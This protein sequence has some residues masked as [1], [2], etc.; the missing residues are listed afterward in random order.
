M[1]RKNSGFTLVELVVIVGMLTVLLGLLVPSLNSILGFR[2]RRAAGAI[3]SALS[4]TKVE[5]MNRLVGEMELTRESDGYYITYHLDRGRGNVQA[6]Q[7]EKIAPKSVR[8]SY[9]TTAS[10]GSEIPLRQGD[11]LILTFNRETGAFRPIQRNALTQS[12]IDTQLEAG[13][14]VTF[15]DK[16]GNPY[17]EKILVRSGAGT[18]TI[19]LIQE[20]GNYVEQ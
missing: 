1:K 19:L 11:S 8:I 9:T 20:T 4:K 15:P 17:C 12:L 7:K 2:G 3:A 5:A 13:E 10:P 16:A 6:D 14:D 18:R